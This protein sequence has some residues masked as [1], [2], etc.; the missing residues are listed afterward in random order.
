M[1]ERLRQRYLKQMGFTPWVAAV[2]LPGAAP[3]PL[4]DMEPLPEVK[5]LPDMDQES[6]A[7]QQGMPE[8]VAALLKT[9]DKAKLAEPP[10]QASAANT[11]P[12]ISQPAAAPSLMFTLQVHRGAQIHLWAEQQQADAPGLNREEL[13]Q[14]A[15]LLKLFGG[16]VASD[17]KR[18][19]CAPTAGKPM[20]AETVRPMFDAF[21]KGLLG[22]QGEIKLLLCAREETVQALFNSPRYEPVVRGQITLLPVSSLTEMLADPAAHKVPSW[23]AM[24]THGFV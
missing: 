14:L 20:T 7:A 17:A 9:D 4:L 21:L 8:Q 3:S 6:P 2:P 23:K 12:A 15:A 13:Q 24:Q 18:F 1:D 5:P 16:T 19:F 11:T 22:R 10:V